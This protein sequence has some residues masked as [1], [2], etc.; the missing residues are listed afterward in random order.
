MASAWNRFW[1]T[2][3]DPTTLGLIR[4][5]AGLVVL[6]IHLVYTFDLQQLLGRNA[7]LDLDTVT[8]LRTQ[9]PAPVPSSSFKAFQ[10]LPPFATPEEEEAAKEY[11]AQWGVDPRVV[12]AKGNVVW[13]IWYYVTDPGWMTVVHAFFLTCMFLFAVGFCTRITSVLTWFGMISYI[14]RAPTTLFGMD[15]MMAIAMVYL[16]IGPSGAA[17]SVDRLIERWW[18]RRSARQRGLPLPE[19]LPPQPRVTANFVIR[20]FQIHFCFIY[21]AAGL[22][23]LQG[24]AWWNGTA[25]WGTMAN[26]AFNPVDLPIYF[27][28]LQFLSRHRWLWELVMNGGCIFTVGLEISLPFLIWVRPLRWLMITGA[29]LLH[30]GIALIMGLIGF[31]LCMLCLLLAFVPPE[32]VHRLLE[33][34]T[35]S[36]RSQLTALG[37]R[38]APAAAPA[39]VSP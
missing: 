9:A 2:P 5:C 7:W 16:V 29:V 12:Y 11:K 10:E 25:M 32:A 31:G 27:Q 4:L 6:Y 23:K 3:A 1:F 8:E 15:T 17:L 18:A 34:L 24:G 14:Q 33:L 20:L 28:M 19:D 36:V 35:S 26:A 22:S 37:L 13:S 38:S 39:A 21:M 30:T